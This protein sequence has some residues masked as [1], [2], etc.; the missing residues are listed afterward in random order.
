MKQIVFLLSIIGIVTRIHV[1]ISPRLLDFIHPIIEYYQIEA[2]H[3]QVLIHLDE[4][5]MKSVNRHR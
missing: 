1:Q 5:A 2:V 3:F 4:G